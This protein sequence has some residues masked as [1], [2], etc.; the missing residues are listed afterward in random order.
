MTEATRVRVV[1]ATSTCLTVGQATE[2]GITLVPLRIGVEGRDYRD[3][4][5]IGPSELYR[6]LRQGVL[7]TTASPSVGDYAAAFEAAP[8]P[9]LCLTVGSRISAMDAAARLAAETMPDRRV[10]IVETGTAAG[11]LR[12]VALAAARLAGEGLELEP[13]GERVR[14]ICARV[15]MSGMLETVEHLARSGRVPGVAHWGTSVLRVRPVIRF[16][17]GSGRL[18]TLVRSPLRGVDEM[19]KL[20]R[21]GAQRQG[22]GPCGEGVFCTVFHGDAASLAE[23]LEHGLREDLPAA[24]LSISE[25]TAA[26]AIHVGPG[27]VGEAFYVDPAAATASPPPG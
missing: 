5:D 7:P 14:E 6:L 25:M 15:E 1:V 3:M 18:A 23:E 8:G 17:A 22:A 2:L 27:V 16:D 21:Q 13:L 12:L 26:M 19:R 4:I 9:V 11:G 20:V 10:E 24:D